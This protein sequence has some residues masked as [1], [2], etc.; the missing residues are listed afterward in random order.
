MMYLLDKRRDL[1]YSN[2]DFYVKHKHSIR[3]NMSYWPISLPR[4][5]S[6]TGLIVEG[7]AVSHCVEN[8]LEALP[9]T[10]K[11]DIITDLVKNGQPKRW[12]H[13]PQRANI[14]QAFRNEYAA[15]WRL[16]LLVAIATIVY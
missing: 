1:D 7:M 9:R 10:E 3:S 13:L 12:F 11:L 5:N 6:D 15:S 14:G 16:S 2:E 8:I 4:F